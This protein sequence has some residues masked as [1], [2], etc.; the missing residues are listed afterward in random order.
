MTFGKHVLTIDAAA[1]TERIFM[2]MCHQVYQRMHRR[3]AVVGIS[4]GI[5]SS[6]VVSLCVTNMTRASS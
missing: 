4:G 3:G 2:M 6:V 5:D 1:E